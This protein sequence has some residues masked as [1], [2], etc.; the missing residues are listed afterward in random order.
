MSARSMAGIGRETAINDELAAWLRVEASQ[1]ALLEETPTEEP[2]STFFRSTWSHGESPG[3]WDFSKPQFGVW[4]TPVLND[5]PVR[6]VAAWHPWEET[7]QEDPAARSNSDR[8]TLLARKYVA[9][10]QFSDEEKAR[11]AIVTERV[12]QLMPA[13]TASAFESLIEVL[14]LVRQVAESDRDIRTKIGIDR[15]K[16][17]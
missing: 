6:R 5:E 14:K 10:E 11:L 3:E 8:I 16:N 12:R 15:Q 9:K 7:T 1:S 13:A 17:G 2:F 4:G